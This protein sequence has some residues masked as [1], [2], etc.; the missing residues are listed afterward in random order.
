MPSLEGT[1]CQYVTLL[2]DFMNW[3]HQILL[4]NLVGSTLLHQE[5]CI[6]MDLIGIPVQ[7]LFFPCTKLLFMPFK[8]NH[9]F[10]LEVLSVLA[11]NKLCACHCYVCKNVVSFW[12]CMVPPGTVK[13]V[14]A[15]CSGRQRYYVRDFVCLL[16]KIELGTWRKQ[17]CF[18]LEHQLNECL[19][20]EIS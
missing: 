20:K 12:H 6:L 1:T 3:P 5:H 8:K 9:S 19:N 4:N 14:T 13:G 2:L 16:K 18:A 15:S 11:V 7:I 10:L 17:V